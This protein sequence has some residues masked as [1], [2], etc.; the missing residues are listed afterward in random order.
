MKETARKATHKTSGN[1]TRSHSVSPAKLGKN[2]ADSAHRGPQERAHAAEA[3]KRDPHRQIHAAEPVKR[4]RKRQTHVTELKNWVPSGPVHIGG[5][6]NPDP[7]PQVHFAGV[8]NRSYAA[9]LDDIHAEPHPKP[10]VNLL[11]GP[12]PVHRK[13]P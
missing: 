7:V 9:H 1:S 10:A 12:F 5:A 13:Q 6:K 3:E 8:E 4:T 11:H 2:S